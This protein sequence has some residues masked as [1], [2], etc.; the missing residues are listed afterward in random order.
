MRN[1]LITL[2]PLSTLLSPTSQ[3]PL[4]LDNCGPTIQD[5]NTPD[6]CTHAI[7]LAQSPTPYGALLTNDGSGLEITYENCFPTIL[8][9]CSV[10]TDPTTPRGAWNWTDAG[11]GCVMGFWLPQYA[12]SAPVPTVDACRNNIYLP[13]YDIGRYTGGTAYNQV[14]VNLA[15]LP[16]D[17][18]NGEAVDVG[19]ASY[20]ISYLPMQSSSPRSGPS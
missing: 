20:T 2:L 16:D 7:T 1:A 11:S 10:L 8:D 4:P 15:R 9:V 6:T 19:Y 18:Q 17:Y 13:M 3:S 12:G 14:S 5:P